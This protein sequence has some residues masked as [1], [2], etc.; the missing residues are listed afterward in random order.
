MWIKELSIAGMRAI[1]QAEFSF[2]PGMNL[3][4]GVN[5]VG[6]TTVLSTVN[7]CISRIFNEFIS[8]S[9]N[10]LITPTHAIRYGMEAV[11]LYCLFEWRNKEY[12]FT[13]LK[14][15]EKIIIETDQSHVGVPDIAVI[16]PNIKFI[17]GEDTL[18]SM[19]IGLYFSARRSMP[20]NREPMKSGSVDGRIAA[21]SEALLDRELNLRPIAQWFQAQEVLSA[22]KNKSS[23]HIESLRSAITSFLPKFNN[24]R[25]IGS[26]NKATF[27]IDKEGIPLYVNQM[28]EG[29][30]GIFAIV[31]DLA[32]RLSQ[33]NPGLEDPV[34]DGQAVV[35]IDELDLHLHP[36]WQRSVVENL[37][38]T[39][40]NCQFIATT[41]SPQIIPAVEPERVQ[42][43]KDGK[44][45]R[46]DRTLGMDT[47]WILRNLMET[48]DRPE[49]AA[50][51][52]KAIES[53]IHEGDYDAARTQMV[54]FREQGLDLP[55]WAMYEARI[56]RLELFDEE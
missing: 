47:N 18:S 2:Q 21:L 53:L 35:L 12:K 42:L 48:D 14:H 4:V 26:G 27:L 1:E 41:H 17:T 52:I 38:R 5:G 20:I 23:N 31:L 9:T 40:P 55:E 43:I 32:R 37:T 33:A 46:P 11:Q 3:I 8:N 24:L 6:K 49:Q 10:S 56:A 13:S 16:T 36:K 15:R 50:E 45:I 51:A 22:E 54:V 7:L 25:V 28:S 34:R 30:R 29:E 39:F 44:V 19:P